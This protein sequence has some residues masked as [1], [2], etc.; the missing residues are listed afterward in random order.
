MVGVVI[1]CCSSSVVVVVV[2]VVK[3]G[4]KRVTCGEGERAK[5]MREWK[6]KRRKNKKGREKRSRRAGWLGQSVLF[7]KARK[8]RGALLQDMGCD[9]HPRDLDLFYSTHTLYLSFRYPKINYVLLVNNQ[10]AANNKKQEQ[11]KQARNSVFVFRLSSWL[12]QLQPVRY[13]A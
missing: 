9:V 11:E 13:G 1:V 5:G 3:K 7:G 6:G 8:K 12:S 4:I 10:K 2:V